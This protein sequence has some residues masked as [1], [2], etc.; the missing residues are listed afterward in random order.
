MSGVGSVWPQAGNQV[1][2]RQV[3]F[4][5]SSPKYGLGVTWNAFCSMWLILLVLTQYLASIL[6]RGR[7]IRCGQGLPSSCPEEVR[8]WI[9]FRLL[10]NFILFCYFT[11]FCYFILFWFSFHSWCVFLHHLDLCFLQ[12]WD[13]SAT[14]W[15]DHQFPD[16]ENLFPSVFLGVFLALIPGFS[17]WHNIPK[18][19]LL[20]EVKVMFFSS[21]IQKKKQGEEQKFAPIPISSQ[22]R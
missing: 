7:E 2:R 14:A 19:H 22:I 21:D 15:N 13:S 11:L 10:M 16:C 3:A 20:R 1:R 17:Q 6:S 5:V 9:T 4:G 8:I 12:V 18:H